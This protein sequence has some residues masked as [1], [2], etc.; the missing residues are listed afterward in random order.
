MS[1]NRCPFPIPLRTFTLMD[2]RNEEP[3]AEPFDE[4]TRLSR[5]ITCERREME[6]ALA[7]LLR[8]A[9]KDWTLR[10]PDRSDFGNDFDHVL[11]LS[12]EEF[13]TRRREELL[14]D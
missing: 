14:I 9:L 13:V 8:K 4:D 6:A 12:L 7:K 10:H 3:S 11:R 1:L 5:W 2:T